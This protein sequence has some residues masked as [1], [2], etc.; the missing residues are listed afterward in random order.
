MQ[1]HTCLRHPVIQLILIERNHHQSMKQM[2]TKTIVGKQYYAHWRR[3]D[4]HMCSKT[5][6]FAGNKSDTDAAGLRFERQEIRPI[7]NRTTPIRSNHLIWC[8][9]NRTTVQ[10]RTKQTHEKSA[11][12]GYA[13]WWRGESC[14]RLSTWCWASWSPLWSCRTGCGS[15]LLQAQVQIY[16]SYS[17]IFC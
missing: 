10:N 8:L 1:S 6:L 9:R 5:M 7:H 16:M 2:R 4:R 17:L 11:V 13:A 12:W 3:P 14:G 15:R